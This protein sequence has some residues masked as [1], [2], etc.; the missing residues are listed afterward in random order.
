M[1]Y[2]YLALAIVLEVLGSSF[3]KASDGFSKLLPTT[4]TII[5]YIACFFFLSQALKSIP[6]GIAYAIWGGLGIVLT[7]LISV[8]IFKQSLDLPAIIGIIL[9]VAGVFV[10]NFFSKSST[11]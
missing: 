2:L 5:A 3:M 4:I 1:K 9:I 10:M 11:H 6:L 8:I 7:A